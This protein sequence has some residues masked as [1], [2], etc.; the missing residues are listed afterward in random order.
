MIYL[1][2]IIPLALAFVFVVIH[3]KDHDTKSTVY[4]TLI[5]GLVSILVQTALYV[6]LTLGSS[7]DTEIINGYVLKKDREEVSCSHSYDCNCYYSTSCSGSGTSRSCTRTRHCSTCYEHSYDV[8]WDV[9]TT[10]GN[11]TIDRIDRRGMGEPPRWAQVQIGEPAA[12]EHSYSNYVLGNKDSLFSKSDQQFAERFKDKIPKYPSVYDYY[13]VGRVLNVSGLS[14]PT[15]YWNDYLNG[16]LR[17]L[18]AA[19]QVNIVWVIT[20]GQPIEYFQGLVYAWDG[21]KKN[22]VIV[23]TDIT[24]DN[25]INWGKSTSFVDG[26]NN[27]ELHAR[28]GL[29]LTGKDMGVGVLADVAANISKGYNRVPMEDMD[30]LKW[31]DLHAWEVLLIVFFGSIP[32]AAIFY[33]SGRAHNTNTY[34]RRYPF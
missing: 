33:M 6:G 24:K 7:S 14:L 12:R 17:T 11:L 13:R 22:D 4:T 10:V 2:F 5:V 25:K 18:G 16:T 29:A 20:S 32:F 15:N 23:V 26:M 27:M 8:D 30:Y 28:N 34:N 9:S 3:R 1:L 31:R 21:G 19:K